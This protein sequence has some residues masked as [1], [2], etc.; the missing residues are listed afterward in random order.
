MISTGWTDEEESKER[1]RTT[2]PSGLLKS[3]QLE[4]GVLFNLGLRACSPSNST[5]PHS[6]P[7]PSSARAHAPY[8][9]PILSDPFDYQI[10]SHT[11]GKST[12]E[13]CPAALLHRL[14]LINPRRIRRL[15]QSR[16]FMRPFVSAARPLHT[17]PADRA[18]S[19]SVNGISYRIQL[20]QL[21]TT[22][23]T[24]QSQSPTLHLHQSLSS[25]ARTW[26]SYCPDSGAVSASLDSQVIQCSYECLPPLIRPY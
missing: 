16:S 20:Q 6:V 18:G 26:A 4:D 14:K 2:S 9:L 5:G 8:I 15:A 1:Q 23:S 17:C 12:P 10:S 24:A 11:Y 21:S 13:V 19:K 22:T 7:T 3:S 25:S